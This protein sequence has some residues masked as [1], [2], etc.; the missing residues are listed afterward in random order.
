MQTVSKLGLVLLGYG[1]AFLVALGVTALYVTST[2]GPDRDTYAGMYAFGDAILFLLVL[3][4][5]SLPATALALYFL[6]HNR[7]FWIALAVL[8]IASFTACAVY[9]FAVG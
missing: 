8:A 9:L 4:V 3:G 5:A 1:M 6:R 2:A 7:P